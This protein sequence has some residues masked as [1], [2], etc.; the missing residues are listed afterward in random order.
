M[1]RSHAPQFAHD[2]VEDLVEYYYRYLSRNLDLILHFEQY[3]NR[4]NSDAK[5]AQAEAVM[6]SLLRAENHE[7]E[8]FEDTGNGGPDF[9]CSSAR[10]KFLMEVTS[11]DSETVSEESGLPME[12]KGQGGGA[13]A[14]ITKKLQAKA[15]AKASQLGG[16]HYPG[17]VAIVSDHVFAGM[18]L[19]RPSA[20][21]LMTS[22]P[23]HN[24]PLNGGPAYTSTDFKHS[25]FYQMTGILDSSGVPIIKPLR[26]SISG[27]LL[28][29]INPAETQVVGLLH[30][31]AVRPFDPTLLP[32]IPFVRAKAP[33]TADYI[34]TEWIQTNR[35]Q[36]TATFLHK[37]LR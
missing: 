32:K 30:P 6:F 36:R 14:L 17:L 34:A 19:D 2:T 21:Y 29:A 12:I 3:K 27:I 18:L 16:Q 7:P 10:G 35:E 13:F 5:A 26:Q 33:F 9:L 8:L 4:L 23:S 1:L 28:C 20:Q 31:E 11:L 37:H 22:A 25:A 24:V 15:K